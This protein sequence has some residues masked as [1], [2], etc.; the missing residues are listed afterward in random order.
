MKV[1]WLVLRNIFSNTYLIEE[2]CHCP[3]RNTRN[4]P[5]HAM[6][7]G[8][9]ILLPVAAWTIFPWLT[10]NI[11]IPVTP[12]MCSTAFQIDLIRR[13][14]VVMNGMKM[15]HSVYSISL[16]P[17]ISFISI[18]VVN[19]CIVTMN[20]FVNHVIQ[21]YFLRAATEHCLYN[22]VG[23]M[24]IILLYIG[25]LFA[26]FNISVYWPTSGGAF[27]SDARKSNLRTRMCYERCTIPIAEHR[28]SPAGVIFYV[29][30]MFYCF[31]CYIAVKK[32]KKTI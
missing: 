18:V 8:L 1:D 5:L 11:F 29:I 32:K 21:M 4:A 23:E 28:R 20:F 10:Y 24:R 13:L 31:R 7:I 25:N 15:Q 17:R 6:H 12:K 26:L 27:K 2:S 16:N 9:V 14:T 19:Q 22:N 3:S 30:A